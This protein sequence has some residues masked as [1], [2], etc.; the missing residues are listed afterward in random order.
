MNESTLGLPFNFFSLFAPVRYVL[1]GIGEILFSVTGFQFFFEES[2][3]ALKVFLNKKRK[4][5]ELRK[6]TK[7]CSPVSFVL[8]IVLPLLFFFNLLNPQSGGHD[9]PVAA[10][11]CRGQR[12]HHCRYQGL[13]VC[14]EVIKRGRHSRIFSLSEAGSCE[15]A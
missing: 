7:P 14:V 5:K 8:V 9:E 1:G 15:Y 6:C 10:D 4:M 3:E 2:P 13:P 12:H 11:R